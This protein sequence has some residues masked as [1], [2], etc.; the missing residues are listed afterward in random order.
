[1]TKQEISKNT[2]ARLKHKFSDLED[3]E[4]KY[5]QQLLNEE[6]Y[7]RKLFQKVIKEFSENE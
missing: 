3:Y 5:L 1:M 6:R 2:Q 7:N 4:K